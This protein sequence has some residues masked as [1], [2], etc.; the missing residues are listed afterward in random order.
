MVGNLIIY[1]IGGYDGGNNNIIIFGG[2]LEKAIGGYK[3]GGYGTIA[4]PS[5]GVGAILA[6]LILAV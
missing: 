4:T 6:D 5:P 1:R 2:F 3:F